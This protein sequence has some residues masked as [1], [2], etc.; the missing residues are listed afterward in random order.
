MKIPDA[1]VSSGNVFADLGFENPEEELAKAKLTIQIRR[2]IERRRLTQ[3]QAGKVLG[4]TQS[5]VLNIIRGQVGRFTLDRLI[6]YLN[7]LDMD[8]EIIT[9]IKPEN[10]SA[11]V[12]VA[13]I[14]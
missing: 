11:T 1:E 2:I 7:A 10:R 4:V 6:K 13:A 3:K 12:M 14:V 9:R 8:V 5:E